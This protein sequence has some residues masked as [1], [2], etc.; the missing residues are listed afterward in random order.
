MDSQPRKFHMNVILAATASDFGGNCDFIAE[1]TS[2]NIK[3]R[4]YE[5]QNGLQSTQNLAQSASYPSS[6]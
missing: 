5:A 3:N 2:K 1:N 6:T 4:G